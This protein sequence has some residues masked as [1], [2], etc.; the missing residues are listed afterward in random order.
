[1]WTCFYDNKG[2][3]K[4]SF[5]EVK[6]MLD[7]NNIEFNENVTMF[8]K[9]IITKDI[10]KKYSDK[11]ISIKLKSNIIISGIVYDNCI[12]E[13]GLYVNNLSKLREMRTLINY[14]NIDS[15]IT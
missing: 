12:L 15:I 4:Y 13:D 2:V 1:M 11:I 9:R 6:Q 8:R 14:D 5:V 7:D 3:C 10:I